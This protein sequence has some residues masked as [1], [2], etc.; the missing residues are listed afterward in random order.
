MTQCTVPGCD[1]PHDAKGLCGAHRYRLRKHGDV[2]HGGPLRPWRP[3]NRGHKPG[4]RF[5]LLVLVERTGPGY[6]LVE[7]D[8]GERT[9]A[10]V[11]NLGNKTTTCGSTAHR[12]YAKRERHGM[13]RGDEVGYAGAHIR[14]KR[15]HGS[16]SLWPCSCGC[17][18]RAD[19]WA[20][21]GGAPD[22]RVSDN[23]L[24]Q[25][26]RY[27]LDIDYYVPLA[28]DCHAKYDTEQRS[29]RK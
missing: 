17:G 8:C 29:K 6:W 28:T 27:S 13:W 21:L 24:S 3:A 12:D 22:E 23:P 14:V 7:C 18:R 11:G 9:T 25:G 16:A 20:Y 10:Y 2:N 15:E 4:E 1:R 5:G 26:L 19:D